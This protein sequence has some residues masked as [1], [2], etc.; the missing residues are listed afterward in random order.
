MSAPSLS[1][2]VFEGQCDLQ[3]AAEVQSNFLVPSY[4][5]SDDKTGLETLK[6]VWLYFLLETQTNCAIKIK[7]ESLTLLLH[8]L[9]LKE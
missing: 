8:S 4:Q 7:R 6:C 2:N 3:R 1:F 9:R 5:D